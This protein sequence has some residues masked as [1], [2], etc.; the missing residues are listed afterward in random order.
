MLAIKGLIFYI[1][2]A[3][4]PSP[5]S[6]CPDFGGQFAVVVLIGLLAPKSLVKPVYLFF[7]WLGKTTKKILIPVSVI[8]F[9]VEKAD[10]LL[11]KWIKFTRKERHS[12]NALVQKFYEVLLREDI[13]ERLIFGYFVTI[14]LGFS[15]MSISLFL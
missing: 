5:P 10:V 14:I 8:G 2:C 12:E 15:L 7:Q 13:I 11:K 6:P 3:L 1:G 4:I 9:V